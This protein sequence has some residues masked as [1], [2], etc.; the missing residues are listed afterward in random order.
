MKSVELCP[1]R[2]S[3]VPEFEL[4]QRNPVSWIM[5]ITHALNLHVKMLDYFPPRAEIT[6][7]AF[8]AS[9]IQTV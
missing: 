3:Y 6:D 1:F 8:C 2:G 4:L 7:M 9:E 5:K